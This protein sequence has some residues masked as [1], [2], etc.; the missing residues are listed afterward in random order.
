MKKLGKLLAM[1]LAGTMVVSAV[2]CGSS[3]NAETTTES[4]DETT[5]SSD[6]T[7]EETA[8]E[9]TDAESSDAADSAE[10]TGSGAP[11]VIGESE[12]SEKYQST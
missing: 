1:G 5:S 4:A 6:E 8:E 12:F 10:S 11:L 2:G 9:A 7:A 3:N